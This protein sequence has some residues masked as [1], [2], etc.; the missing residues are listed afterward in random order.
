MD[1][2]KDREKDEDLR[3]RLTAEQ[4]RVTQEK[5][6]EPPYA[7]KYWNCN[8][9]GVYRCVCCDAELFDSDVKHK[10]G[11]GWPCFTNPIDGASIV[12]TPD[13]PKDPEKYEVSCG[14]C[15]AHLGYRFPDE[16]HTRGS[17]VKYCINSASVNLD[18]RKEEPTE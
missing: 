4:Y 6:S 16:D 11:C 9:G 1:T 12:E 17:K 10:S 2:L 3:K 7:N 15:G 8:D 13:S 14:K 18:P 5:Y